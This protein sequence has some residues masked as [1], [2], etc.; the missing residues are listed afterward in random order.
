M[1]SCPALVRLAEIEGERGLSPKAFVRA[2]ALNGAGVRQGLKGTFD[3]MKGA[4]NIFLGGG[5]RPLYSD[6]TSGQ[7]RHFCGVLGACGRIG[8]SLTRLLSIVVRHDSP[9]SA[10]VI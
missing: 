3:L 1:D 5:F 8:P 7:V 6:G 10:D 9:R 4:T 2:L